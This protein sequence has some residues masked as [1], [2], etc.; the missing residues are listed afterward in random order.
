MNAIENIAG[1][2]RAFVTTLGIAVISAPYAVAASGGEP[3]TVATASSARTRQHAASDD[4]AIHLFRVNVPQAALD[5]LR[6]RLLAT[7]WPDKETV[8]DRSQGPQLAQLQELVQYWG[9]SYDWRKAEAKLNALPQFTTSIDG[10]DLHFIHVRSRHKNARALLIAHGWPGSVF[11]QMKLIDPLTD[12]TRHGGRAEDAFDVVIPSLPGFGFSSRPTV[13][14]WGLERMGRAFDVLMKRL[15]YRRYVAQGGDWGAGIV[16]AMARQAPAG[17][18]NPH[19]VVATFGCRLP[20]LLSLIRVLNR[21]N[22]TGCRGNNSIGPLFFDCKKIDTTVRAMGCE[23]VENLDRYG[24]AIGQPVDALARHR[25]GHRFLNDRSA[26]KRA[27][28]NNDP[29]PLVHECG[30]TLEHVLL[31]RSRLPHTKLQEQTQ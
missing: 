13:A 12:P 19:I 10:V 30:S 7:R 23:I 25:F 6:K 5:D 4:A 21:H 9:S 14:G 16:E 8:A 18:C 24:I 3:N 26:A 17:V 2:L 11:E 27:T 29:N 28:E 22:A 31:Q 20:G 15:G 1:K